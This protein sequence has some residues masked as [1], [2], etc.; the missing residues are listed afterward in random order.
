MKTIKLIM[1]AAIVAILS[2][3]M[4]T[5][6]T[7]VSGILNSSEITV[8]PGHNAQFLDGVKKWK[9]CYLENEGGNKW[10]MLK[11]EQG[12]GNVYL[13]SGN[14][15]KWA[16]MDKEEA[17]DKACYLTLMNFIWPHLE[18]VNSRVASTMPEVSSDF[19]EGTK[20]IRVT[21]YEVHNEAAFEYVISTVTKAMK[22]KEGSYRGIW[23]N[24]ELGGPETHDFMI[25]EPFKKYADMDLKRDSPQKIY[26]DLV[27][28]EKAN[29]MWEI[30][31][32]TLQNSWS[33][34]YKL[35]TEL[36]N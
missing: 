33:Y 11:R 23:Y 35:E 27:G 28:E 36:S 14:M 19:P 24:T 10:S 25:T 5:A 2:T 29:E 1:T 4:L 6:Q 12:E 9:A 20:Y 18:K 15:A 22:D 30:W 31:F 17:A 8:K 16:E 3:G 13:L 21:Y 34:T 32:A 26:T 7:T